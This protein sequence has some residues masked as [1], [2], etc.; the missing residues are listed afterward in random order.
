MTFDLFVLPFFFGLLFLIG[1]LVVKYSRWI[2]MM[3]SSDRVK[4]GKALFS[5]NLVKTVKEIFMESLLHRRMFKRNPLLGFMHMSFALGWFL[6]IV[7]GNVESRVYSGGHINPPYYPIF[8]KFFIH[9]KRVMPFEIFTLPG[10]FRFTMDL[11]LL[12]VLSGLVLALF[13]R[14]RS[15]WF[16]LKRTTQHN[17]FD[18]WAITSLWL[19]FPMRLLAESFTAGIYQGGG[20]LTNTFG[21]FLAA[22]LPEKYLVYPAWWAYSTMLGV[23]FV[24][25]PWSRFM[26]IP[27]EII[28]I[29]LRNAGIEQ[30]KYPGS[31]SEIELRSC[32]RCGVCID[33][34]QM[35]TAGQTGSTAVYFI[36]SLREKRTDI[37]LNSNC[38][39]CGRCLE[40]CPVGIDTLGLRVG[41]RG[42]DN[43]HIESDFSYLLKQHGIENEK[44]AEVVYFAGCMGHLTPGVTRAM[45]QI[46]E[47]ADINFTFL[48]ENGSICCGRPLKLAGLH[49]AASK[50]IVEN[51]TKL[52]KT[53]AEILVTSCPICY[54]VFNND[55]RLD[56]M[57]VMHHSVYIDNLVKEGKLALQPTELQSVYHDPCELG[58]GSGIYEQPRNVLNQITEVAGV[59][60]ERLNSLCCGGSIGDLLMNAT[61]RNIIRDNALEILCEPQP[62]VLVTACPLCKKSFSSANSVVVK[63]IAELVAEN[64]TLP[65]S[66]AKVSAFAE[67]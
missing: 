62:D 40:A 45:V 27:T 63:D 60:E 9:D 32:P 47:K 7:M 37:Q 48:D 11:L 39:M 1:V 8:L 56:G 64:M 22:F 44:K 53:S 15:R 12:F 42:V 57:Q 49:E 4:A 2:A 16:G 46:F 10:F 5:Y 24:T 35:N 33:V 34:C 31:F 19:I 58:R 29:F 30:G 50:L 51:T 61:Q 25:L 41:A 36:R 59:Q 38:M 21:S 18:K 28:L 43:Q 65:G 23:F 14:T 67:Q 17:S 54:K 13:K 55:Y 52:Q 26:H 3:D 66:M 20:F 6:L